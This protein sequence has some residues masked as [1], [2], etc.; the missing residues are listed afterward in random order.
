MCVI[1]TNCSL[2]NYVCNKN[3]YITI[4]NVLTFVGIVIL[5][6]TTSILDYIA[7]LDIILYLMKMS[8]FVD[9]V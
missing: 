8:A 9:K 5:H 7:R 4:L 3:N 1:V 6:L 2:Y